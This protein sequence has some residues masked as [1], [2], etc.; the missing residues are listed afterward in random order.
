MLKQV[1]PPHPYVYIGVHYDEILK[2]TNKKERVSRPKIT[3]RQTLEII[4]NECDVTVESILS[5]CRRHNIVDARYICFAALKLKYKLSLNSI[6]KI[7]HRKDH[8]TI[9]HGL[10]TFRNRYIYED[11]YRDTVKRIF[12]LLY[13]QYDGEKLTMAN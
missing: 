9:I 12:E 4:A 5:E 11:N 7:A 10:K 8:T 13:I 3:K 1:T 2:N 6:C